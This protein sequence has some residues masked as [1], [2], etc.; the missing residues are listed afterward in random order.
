MTSSV[1]SKYLEFPVE[2]DKPFQ[3]PTDYGFDH[4]CMA[5]RKVEAETLYYLHAIT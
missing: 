4:Y 1:Q 5:C 3:Q 2:E